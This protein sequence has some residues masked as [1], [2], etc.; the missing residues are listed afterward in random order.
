ME[1]DPFQLRKIL[2]V[3]NPE[4][5]QKIM[6]LMGKMSASCWNPL[7]GPQTLAY[8]SEADI[9]FYGGCVS[10]ETEF[11]TTSGWKKIS[12]Y[13][14]TDLVAQW[15]EKTNKIILVYPDNYI[16]VPCLYF[17]QF[18]HKRLS[19][20]LS[21]D[22]R[23]PLYDYRDKFIVKRASEIEANPSRYKVPVNFIPTTPGLWLSDKLIRLAVAIYA[24]GNLT[25]RK[26]K[27]GS[28][29]RVTLRKDRKKIRLVELLTS[30]GIKWHEYINPKRPSEVRYGFESTITIKHF[31]DG[32]WDA[33][34]HQLSVILDE[35]SY[36]DGNISGT[37]GGDICF[38]TTLK[39]DADFIQYAAHACSRVATISTYPVKKIEHSILYKVHIS[40]EGSV[41]STVTLRGDAISIGRIPGDLMYCFK[42]PTGFWLA[43]HNGFIFVTGNSAGGGKTDLLCGLSITSHFR[44]LIM[45]RVGTEL[46]D[47]VDRMIAIVGNKEGLNRSYPV[48]WRRPDGR[49]IEFGACNAIGDEA[50]HQGHAHS[51]KGFDEITHFAESQFRYLCGWLRS[52]RKGERCRVVACGNPPTDAQGQ[53]VLE[54]WGPWLNEDHPN[55]AREGELRYFAML[56][57]KDYERPHG[58]PFYY[59]CPH[60]LKCPFNKP[61]HN[62]KCPEGGEYIVPTSR[63]FIRSSVED[64]PFLMETGYKQ[65]LQALPEPLRS[66]MLKGDFTAGKGDDP[67][68]VLP[69][70]WVKAAQ[71]RWRP[72]GNR[73]KR[74]DSMGVDVSRG[75]KDRT[76]LCPRY[77]SWYGVP[78]VYPGSFV[79]DGNAAAGLVFLNLKDAAPVHIDIVNCGTSA[80][81]HLNNNDIYVIAING[82]ASGGGT[83]RS[84]I[85]RFYNK[86]AE[87]YWKFREALDPAYGSEVA[88]PPGNEVRA[89]LCA[90]K[91]GL[92][93]KF[94]GKGILV[95]AKE[96]I[97]K[98]IGRS[99]DLGESILYASVN[100]PRR[101]QPPPDD[102]IQRLLNM[103]GGGPSSMCG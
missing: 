61:C 58:R 11:L 73:G 2:E 103:R 47:I 10:A 45:R 86:R 28:Y 51:L 79:T 95:E 78:I 42:V 26:N 87:I 77:G 39:T 94:D 22:H 75:G 97:I 17:V 32:W 12:D 4:E 21:P 33:N 49:F 38:N 62:R 100:T 68:Q 43:R 3:A 71:D 99:P 96:D 89:E 90:A 44:S 102:E 29:C 65:A 1:F 64:N 57:G 25:I 15:D 59:K 82:T 9:S 46:E 88:L 83:D 37:K 74:M 31:D 91:W 54:Y 18:R 101:Q 60:D 72:D 52:T 41:K 35:I 36:W 7:P 6:A 34:Q 70:L 24:D 20:V 81:D 56:D 5:T 16:S 76:C 85:L 92:T 50:K 27:P 8:H 40:H 93:T 67:W 13:N 80:Y 23:M 66:Q 48:T 69:T 19:M 63:T 53:W 55:P 14:K 98:R 84:G 30:L